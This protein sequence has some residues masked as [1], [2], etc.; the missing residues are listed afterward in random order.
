[1]KHS[2]RLHLSR[3]FWFTLA[4]LAPLVCAR[5]GDAPKK[6]INLLF[7]MTDQQRWDAM[8][9]AGNPVLQ[10]PNLDVLAA[11]G[12]RFSRFYSA[13]PVCVPA[14]T[15]ILTGHSPSSNQ[16]T[17]NNDVEKLG[18]PTTPSFDQILL[19]SGYHGKYH[20]K[21]HSPYQLAL[22]YTEPVRWLNGKRRPPTLDLQSDP[23][24]LNNLIGRNPN[25]EKYRAKVTRLKGLLV[26]WLVRT[27]SPH[28]EGV[29][30]RAVLAEAIQP[31]VQR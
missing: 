24:E 16:I 29:K 6:P 18:F 28:L 7:I 13:C 5:A 22:E 4:L 11:Q 8:S 14:R 15:A 1:M 3:L 12:A 31:K 10:T 23:H 30:A 21:Y 25:R 17:S 19:R 26:D 20:G 9:A 2:F 27:K